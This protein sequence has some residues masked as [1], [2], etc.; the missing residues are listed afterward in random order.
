[1]ASLYLLQAVVNSHSRCTIRISVLVAFM[2]L[3]SIL[4]GCV[5]AYQ[6]IHSDI[7]RLQCMRHAW[8]HHNEIDVIV[9]AAHAPASVRCAEY[10]STM[11]APP[12]GPQYGARCCSM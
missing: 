7:E 12:S 4:L 1:M 6:R 5:S 2:L 3:S 8:W 10:V 9:I 11:S